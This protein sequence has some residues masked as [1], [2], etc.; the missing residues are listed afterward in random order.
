MMILMCSDTI[1]AVLVLITAVID[2]I[3]VVVAVS[4]KSSAP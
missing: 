4:S 3:L 1:I 2:T